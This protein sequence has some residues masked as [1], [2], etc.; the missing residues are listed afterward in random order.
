MNV[1]VL[2]EMWERWLAVSK[3]YDAM[4]MTTL[5][6][7]LYDASREL[8]TAVA[9]HSTLTAPTLPGAGGGD[10]TARMNYL[11]DHGYPGQFYRC[12]DEAD[13]DA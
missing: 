5:A 7:V 1:E 11:E 4:G 9:N 12:D 6:N 13:G 2:K 10:D 3:E 8:E